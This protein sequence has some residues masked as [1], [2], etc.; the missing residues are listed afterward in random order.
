MVANHPVQDK[1]SER[2]LSNL[3][4]DQGM[5]RTKQETVVAAGL[6]VAEV[7]VRMSIQREKDALFRRLLELDDQLLQVMEG[8]ENEE[9]KRKDRQMF[10]LAPSTFNLVP[11]TFNLA[12]SNSSSNWNDSKTND[13]SE[14]GAS[15]CKQAT[16]AQVKGDNILSKSLKGL[17]SEVPNASSSVVD[18][19][20]NLKTDNGEY[21]NIPGDRMVVLPM[22]NVDHPFMVKESLLTALQSNDEEIRSR[23]LWELKQQTR[24]Y[25]YQGQLQNRHGVERANHS[26]YYTETPKLEPVGT[27]GATY[28]APPGD[29]WRSVSQLPA[30]T[31]VTKVVDSTIDSKLVGRQGG[32]K[33]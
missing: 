33:G 13:G 2:T 10:N 16:F 1:R 5:A 14:S 29:Y 26:L 4:Q 3:S 21:E 9:N 7:D 32:I 12:P 8:E 30:E 11:S 19:R 31:M 15:Q 20:Y 28:T 23:A 17:G 25:E 6:E 24:R 27:R 22:G 18:G